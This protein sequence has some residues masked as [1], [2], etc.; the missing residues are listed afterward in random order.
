M[1]RRQ[2]R[3]ALAACCLAFLGAARGAEYSWSVT[4][5]STRSELDPVGDTSR[6]SVAA[7][8]YFGGVEDANAPLAL[9]EFF[10]PVTRVGAAVARS[11]V[12]LRQVGPSVVPLPELPD[13]SPDSNEAT[14]TGR[15]VLPGAARWYFGGRYTSGDLDFEPSSLIERQHAVAYSLLGGRYLG[16]RTSI[17]L[18]LDRSD[19]RTRGTGIVCVPSLFCAAIAPETAQTMLDTVRVGVLHVQQFRALTY[20]L[21][22]GVAATSGHTELHLGEFTLPGLGPLPPYGP[23]VTVPAR[24]VDIDMDRFRVY[25]AAAEL[26]PTRKLGVRVG[27]TRWDGSAASDRAYD[28]GATWFVTRNV[29]LRF[30][31]GR[32]RASAELLGDRDTDTRGLQVIGRF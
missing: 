10:D 2:F 15:Y 3:S 8:Y 16:H 20:A 31:L 24:T 18:V 30:S 19:S 1:A 6:S 14:V 13:L 12:G 9:A 28:V 7:D 26:F 25:T 27:Y 17:E 32:Q 22:G 21:S 29:A 4:A 11:H 5:A 23:V